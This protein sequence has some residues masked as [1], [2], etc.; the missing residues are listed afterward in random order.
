MRAI[1]FTNQ[2]M[3]FL[4]L[5]SADAK[6]WPIYITMPVGFFSSCLFDWLILWCCLVAVAENSV[7]TILMI[8]NGSVCVYV[9]IKDVTVNQSFPWKRKKLVSSISLSSPLY[10][11]LPIA[12]WSNN[13]IKEHG[14]IV[15]NQSDLNSI[16]NFH[17]VNTL[18]SLKIA[19]LHWA[20]SECF[21]HCLFSSQPLTCCSCFVPSCLQRN[22][23][24]TLPC[25]IVFTFFF[26]GNMIELSWNG[27]KLM[28]LIGS[29]GITPCLNYQLSKTWAVLV[30][31]LLQDPNLHL[32]EEVTRL[33]WSSAVCQG[34]LRLTM[35][36]QDWWGPIVLFSLKYFWS[37]AFLPFS[38]VLWHEYFAMKL[39][40]LSIL[41]CSSM[42]VIFVTVL[43]GI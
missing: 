32:A 33:S 7:V 38:I 8:L 39:R 9:R 36:G 42:T 16:S 35:A 31:D 25:D 15:Y 5:N 3:G 21:G 17:F 40:G 10:A 14:P 24:V 23:W 28:Q 11:C 18:L 26:F 22:Y 34:Q 30:Q 29:S 20:R 6:K 1:W 43:I 4:F 37:F 12:L 13:K 27:S 19:L 2:E 41:V